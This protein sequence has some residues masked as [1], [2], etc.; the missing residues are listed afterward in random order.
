MTRGGKREGAGRKVG[1]TNRFSK[2][3]L[4]RAQA[5]GELPVDYLL[6][7]MR[8]NAEDTRI[9]LDAAKAAAPYLHHRLASI[10]L[11][12]QAAELSHEDWLLELK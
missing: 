12:V 1:S 4:K 7:V 9:R 10:A 3:L 6:T 8:D 2:D 5:E 11:N